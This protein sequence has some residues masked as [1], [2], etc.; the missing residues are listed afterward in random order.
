M[1]VPLDL[2]LPPMMQ[3]Y[4]ASLKQC[5]YRAK[6]QRYEEKLD[7]LHIQ[8]KVSSPS[9]LSPDPTTNEKKKVKEFKIKR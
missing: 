8:S 1:L 6:H 4:L 2:F 9:F 5:I 7:R 3:D